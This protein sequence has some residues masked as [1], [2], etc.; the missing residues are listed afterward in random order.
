[1]TRA[2]RSLFHLDFIA[3][4]HY[5][6]LF[7]LPIPAL[8]LFLLHHHHS[9]KPQIFRLGIIL[10]CG[11]FLLVYLFRLLNPNDLI[12]VWNPRQGLLARIFTS[13]KDGTL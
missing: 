6:P 8:I 13:I 7:W 1:M 12:V 3:A 10:I 11:L 2:W 5:H 4:F 9:I